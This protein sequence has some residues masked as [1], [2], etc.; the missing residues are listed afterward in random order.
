MVREAGSTSV[1]L[2]KHIDDTG[3]RSH[4]NHPKDPEGMCEEVD[5]TLGSKR[6]IQSSLYLPSFRKSVNLKIKTKSMS[7]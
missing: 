3:G 1:D 5:D 6:G 7:S 4:K 2:R